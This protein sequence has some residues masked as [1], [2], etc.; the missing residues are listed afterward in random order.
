VTA[1]SVGYVFNG[2]SGVETLS[3]LDQVVTSSFAQFGSTLPDGR[4]IAITIAFLPGGTASG[5]VAFY[6][7]PSCGSTGSGGPFNATRH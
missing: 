7:P 4:G 2:C 1:V 5:V 3:G 6:G